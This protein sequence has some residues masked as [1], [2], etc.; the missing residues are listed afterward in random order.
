MNDHRPPVRA[1][2]DERLG[3][4]A[5]IVAGP[6]FAL[7][8]TAVVRTGV[9]EQPGRRYLARF[10]STAELDAL[11]RTAESSARPA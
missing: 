9:G 1:S 7:P 8:A 10:L 3:A 5:E 4:L 2:L 6:E 11:V